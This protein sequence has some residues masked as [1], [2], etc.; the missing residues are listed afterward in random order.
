MYWGGASWSA[1]G[2]TIDGTNGAEIGLKP[3]GMRGGI[4]HFTS[5]TY[6]DIL[7]GFRGP[8]ASGGELDVIRGHGGAWP[9]RTPYWALSYGPQIIH[10]I[11]NAM[12]DTAAVGM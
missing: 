7:I 6:N 8:P 11:S 5:T 4:G 2:E 10:V 12:T 9:V 1:A 3:L